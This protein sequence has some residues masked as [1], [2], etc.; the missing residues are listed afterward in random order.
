MRVGASSPPVAEAI[1]RSGAAWKE[2]DDSS[3]TASTST[4]DPRSRRVSAAS[5]DDDAVSAPSESTTTMR[6]APGADPASAVFAA[7]A[8]PS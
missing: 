5:V 8:I 7:R 1:W 3:P 4:P 2:G 6:R